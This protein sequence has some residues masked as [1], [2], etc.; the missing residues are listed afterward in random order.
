MTGAQKFPR[1]SVLKVLFAGIR[2]TA[3]GFAA[4]TTPHLSAEEDD[5]VA[6]E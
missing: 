3:S 4:S 6:R 1:L 5:A 2:L